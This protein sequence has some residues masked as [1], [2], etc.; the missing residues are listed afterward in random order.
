MKMLEAVD[1]ADEMSVRVMQRSG[2]STD[3]PTS[4][5]FPNSCPPWATW[6]KRWNKLQELL[7]LYDLK[8][9]YTLSFLSSIVIFASLL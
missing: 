6:L 9:N 1:P 2:D 5:S 7:K 3:A 8:S 4:S